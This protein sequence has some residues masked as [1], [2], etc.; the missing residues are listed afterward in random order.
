MMRSEKAVTLIELVIVMTIM[1]V[2]ATIAI[3]LYYGARS[4][5]KASEAVNG[6]GA[7]RKA[8]WMYRAEHGLYPVHADT[9]QVDSLGLDLANDDLQGRYFDNND[10]TYTGDATTFTLMATGGTDPDTAPNAD[11]VDGIVRTINQDGD[12]ESGE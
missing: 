3:P 8:L 5:F 9:V 10:Y 6:L 4:E 7:I 2:L 1:A 11:E 12:I